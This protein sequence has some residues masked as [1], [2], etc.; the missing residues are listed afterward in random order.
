[1]K[2]PIKDI[3]I[4]PDRIRKDFD[5]QA[6]DDLAESI[7]TVG[8]IEP[9]VLDDD[10]YLL[11]GE[12]RLRA[13]KLLGHADAEI[14]YMR[15]LDDWKKAVVELEENLRREDLTYV[16][17]VMA[18]KRLHELYQTKHGESS[19]YGGRG[20]NE[21]WKVK[22]T[23]DLLGISVGSVSQDIQLAKAIEQDPELGNQRNKL[24]ATAM[25][26]RKQAIKARSLLAILTAKKTPQPESTSEQ[27]PQPKPDIQLIHGDCLSVIPTLPDNS[28]ACMITDPPWQVAFD[29]E[30]GQDP[31]TG[32][33]LTRDMLTAMLPKLHE[34]ALCFMFCA[35][36]HLMKGSVYDLVLEC[37]Y[38]VYNSLFIWYKPTVAHSSR[39]Y[40]ELKKDYEPALL[41]S[42][43]H[44]RDLVHPMFAVY[45]TK[46]QGRKLHPA[47]KPTDMLKALID[48][49][50]VPGELIIDPFMGS[51]STMI[52]CK[53]TNRR[54]IGIELEQQWF[55]LAEA[56]MTLTK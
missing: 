38:F 8:L 56:E 22:D 23:A 40:R 19:R 39:P 48:V 3:Y 16:E 34:G 13:L 12:R 33:S 46:L 25:L 30:F 47:Q 29:T 55:S 41:F 51:G 4:R 11:A 15:D 43:G 53:Q 5:Q 21:G 10:N 35:M 32:L 50:T 45:Q 6:L 9:I 28:I 52:A 7:R 17:E 14:V 37:G 18:K 2:F 54:G 1:V 24:A 44:G 36:N 31:T 42:K 27:T 49:A 20:H 26:N